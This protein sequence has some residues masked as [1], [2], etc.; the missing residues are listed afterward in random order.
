METCEVCGKATEELYL[1]R[2]E[3]ATMWVCLSCSRGKQVLQSMNIKQES[4]KQV[5]IKKGKEEEEIAENY[6]EVIRK[7]RDRLGLPLKV[8]AERISEKES[9]LV[10]VEKQKTLPSESLRKRLEKELGIKLTVKVEQEKKQVTTSKNEPITI[11][12]AAFS[13]KQIDEEESE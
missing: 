9:E 12:D 3:E 5:A 13:K 6:G 10:R 11:G 7:A 2:I 4:P 8:L 1:A